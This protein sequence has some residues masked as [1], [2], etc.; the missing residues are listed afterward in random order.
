MEYLHMKIKGGV[1]IGMAEQPSP[2]PPVGEAKEEVTPPKKRGTKK[3][4]A[5]DK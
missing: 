3:A 1:V 5:N 4:T 2:T